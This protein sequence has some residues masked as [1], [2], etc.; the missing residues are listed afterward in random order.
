M[1]RRGRGGGGT[2]CTFCWRTQIFPNLRL[3]AFSFSF[4]NSRQ[5]W[6]TWFYTRKSNKFTIRNDYYFR[7]G[8]LMTSVI[9]QW[10]W[11]LTNNRKS[12]D[13]TPRNVISHLFPFFA[14]LF[15]KGGGTRWGIIKEGGGRLIILPPGKLSCCF[16]FDKFGF[17][18][19]QLDWN[20][21]FT[22]LIS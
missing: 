4:I 12:K 18:T 5:L 16:K 13:D 20:N 22:K 1:R 7:K 9:P 14:G 3:A 10:C 17:C 15:I 21:N 8:S 6:W 19:S 11:K 2:D